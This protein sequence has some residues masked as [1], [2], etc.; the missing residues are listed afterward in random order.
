MASDLV[1][2]AREHPGKVGYENYQIQFVFGMIGKMHWAEVI[3]MI[4]ATI[5][6]LDLFIF[7]GK[8]NL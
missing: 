5:T 2:Y 7:V 4:S 8:I 1:L 6:F 3:L